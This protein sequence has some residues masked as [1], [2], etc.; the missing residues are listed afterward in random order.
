[1]ASVDTVS[2]K[3][4]PINLG[5][6][7]SI[8]K[9]PKSPGRG[10]PFWYARARIKAGGRSLHIKSTRTSDEALAKKRAQ[11]FLAELLVQ[12]R[13]GVPM[14][15]GQ[16]SDRPFRFDVIADEWLDCLFNAAGDDDRKLRRYRDH[17]KVVLGSNGLR[18]FFKH[19]DIRAITTKS[20]H[21]FLE[22]A[23]KHSRKGALK[24]TTKR[25]LLSSLRAI[26]NFALDMGLVQRLPR[27]PTIPMKDNPRAS[28]SAV[29]YRRL[30]GGCSLARDY[31]IAHEDEE[32]ASQFE[33]LRLFIR[34]MVNSFLRPSEWAE[35]RH[36][37]I[38]IIE[39]E[40]PYLRIAVR[41]GKTRQR[42]AVTMPGAVA[43]YRQ[44]E[45]RNGC[46]PDEFVFLPNYSNRATALEVMRD[47]FNELLELTE[48]THDSFGRKRV[49]Y[50]LRHTALTLRVLNGDNVDR[51][52]L[53]KNA[54]TSV[55]MLERFYC[56]DLDPE[57]KIENLQSFRR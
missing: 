37:D 55:R 25:N 17:R 36:R 45:K 6:G 11:G 49:L 29:E 27:F 56:N 23:E 9:Q 31:Y 2:R 12:Q 10:S 39:G 43:A 28:F 24:P 41:R 57:A 40:H 34:F 32:R 42:K 30:G 3:T 50:S 48:L 18:P 16:L 46:N 13:T 52:T 5:L 19:S 33:E 54:G 38:E 20:V 22:F 21:D 35:I 14:A 44:I 53:A 15:N 1:M 7:L 26:L 51:M 8:Y 47:R 4:S